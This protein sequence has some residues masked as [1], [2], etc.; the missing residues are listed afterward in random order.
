MGAG[1]I[2]VG[3]L[4]RNRKKERKKERNRNMPNLS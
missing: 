4:P 1:L 3:E 2:Q